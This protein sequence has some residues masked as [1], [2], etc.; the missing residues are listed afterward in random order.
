MWRLLIVRCARTIFVLSV[1]QG[2]GFG[3]VSMV[4]V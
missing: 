3:Y 1:A 2:T 4:D